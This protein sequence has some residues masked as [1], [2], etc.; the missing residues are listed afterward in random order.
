MQR[1]IRGPRTGL[2]LTIS[3]LALVVVGVLVILFPV[4]G[5]LQRSGA[6][7]HALRE[8]RDPGAALTHRLP[9]VKIDTA[10][11]S[12]PGAS[13]VC[14]GGSSSAEYALIDFPSLSGIEGVAGDGTWALL[15][16]RSVVHY[17]SS[18]GPGQAG[19][20]IYAVHR[21]PNFEPLGTLSAGDLITVTNRQ[22]QKFTYR[23][24]NLWTENPAQVTQLQP[25]SSGSWIT[26]ITCT[27]LWVDSQRLVIRAELESP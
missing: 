19:N 26:V 4:L 3:G 5:L 6:D 27:P 21:E 20:G 25:L 16:Q 11:G 14:G 22:C 13:Q 18:P 8:W 2:V 17:A 12:G 23:I 1:L 10:L 7:Q 15:T 24:T 9:K